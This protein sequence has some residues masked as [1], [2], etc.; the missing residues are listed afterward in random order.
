MGRIIEERHRLALS[1][2]K[3]AE[4]RKFLLEVFKLSFELNLSCLICLL[5]IAISLAQL[6]HDFIQLFESLLQLLVLH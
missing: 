6:L 3:L 2:E 1:L 4:L 5:I